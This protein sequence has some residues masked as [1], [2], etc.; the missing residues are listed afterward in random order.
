M[1]RVL[2]LPSLVLFGLAYMSPLAVFVTYGIVSKMTLGHLSTAYVVTLIAILFTALSYSRMAKVMP[3]S[4]SAYTYTSKS[5]GSSTGF[6]VG[7]T[8]LL[9]YLF[10]PMFTYLV[11]GI[12]LQEYFPE[13]H[14]YVWILLLATLVC[15]LN[16]LGIKLVAKVNLILVGLQLI[17]VLLFVLLSI[18][19]LYHSPSHID[20]LEPFYDSK[21]QLP[22]VISGSAIL[23]LSFLGFE[24]ISTLAGEAQKPA[25]DIPLA[26]MLCTLVS[27]LLYILVAY[28]GQLVFPHWPANAN[29]DTVSLQLI[30]F[31]GG[32]GFYDFY[33][34]MTVTGCFSCAMASLAGVCRVLYTMGNNGVLPR[35]FGY[36]NQRYQ[37]PAFSIVVVSLLSLIAIF[38]SLELVTS[39]INF[40]ALTA[41]TFVNLSVIKHFYVKQAQR[42]VLT[43]LL[44]PLIGFGLTVWLWTS[45][46]ATS[47]TVGLCWLAFGG[48]YLWFQRNKTLPESLAEFE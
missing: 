39:M 9:D 14:S 19:V 16:L 4:G 43:N 38:L 17:F 37:T 26:I 29:P 12:Y 18:M 32:Q 28:F 6:L 15:V 34:V 31:I 35:P 30:A 36:L 46:S 21:M 13:I 11:T 5:F 48:A 7:W 40:G 3:N 42:K 45:L 10:T 33:I 41:F 2:A 44:L 20:F 24:S 23:C 8:L 25:K 27:G 47:I 22:L 1:K